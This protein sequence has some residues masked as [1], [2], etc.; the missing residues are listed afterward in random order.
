MLFFFYF[1]LSGA[2]GSGQI[3]VMTQSS[4]CPSPVPFRLL[5]LL[6]PGLRQV[7]PGL[8]LQRGIGQMQLLPLKCICHAGE[9]AREACVQHISQGVGMIVQ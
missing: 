3:R 8:H 7:C 1:L 5:S 2:G 4:S 6:P 9:K